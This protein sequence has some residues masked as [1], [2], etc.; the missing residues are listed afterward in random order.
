MIYE[1]KDG[2]LIQSTKYKHNFVDDTEYSFEES[3]KNL[4][5]HGEVIINMNFDETFGI[6]VLEKTFKE[7]DET[8][9]YLIELCIESMLHF[10]VAESFEDYMSFMA[11]YTPMIDS[12]INIYRS[13]IY[14]ETSTTYSELGR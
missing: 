2:I 6:K 7:E 13:Q 9:H 4:G 5:W 1:T 8:T 10:V 11:K 14:C 12:L 3:L